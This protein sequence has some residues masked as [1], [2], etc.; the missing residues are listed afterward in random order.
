MSLGTGLF[1]SVLV[2]SLVVIYAVTKDRWNWQR[3]ALWGTLGPLALVVVGA[4][5]GY[6]VWLW[7]DIPRPLESFFGI[8]LKASEQ[9]V[10]FMKGAP[11][12]RE[13]EGRRWVYEIKDGANGRTMATY[14]VQFRNG[15]VRYVFYSPGGYDAGKEYPFGFS[16]GT[17]IAQVAQKLGKPTFVSESTD[18]SKRIY[19]YADYNVFFGF[20]KGAVEIYGMYDPATGPVTLGEQR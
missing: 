6:V 20:S 9:D 16:D 14:L 1:L 4:V 12:K 19:S 15:R 2:V 8:A 18:G 13:A 5:T 7:Q 11:T 10:R 17:G 3:I